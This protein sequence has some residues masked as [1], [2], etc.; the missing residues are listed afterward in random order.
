MG[1]QL[2]FVVIT[3]LMRS[4]LRRWSTTTSLVGRCISC[5]CREVICDDGGIA[6]VLGEAR[7]DADFA[8]GARAALL[9][10]VGAIATSC[11]SKQQRQCFVCFLWQSDVPN[12]LRLRK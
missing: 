9:R 3:I 4:K 1:R 11:Q 6:V 2:T 8:T 12:V 10:V 5:G 7:F